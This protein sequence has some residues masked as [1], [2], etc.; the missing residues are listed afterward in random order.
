[1]IKVKMQKVSPLWILLILAPLSVTLTDTAHSQTLPTVQAR[2]GKRPVVGSIEQEMVVPEVGEAEK[3]KKKPII[4]PSPNG[5]GREID[6]QLEGTGLIFLP[7]N[8][9]NVVPEEILEDKNE[10]RSIGPPVM[11]AP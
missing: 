5:P 2:T 7:G 3:S 9:G 10:W 6:K 11:D 1:M 8:R 4:A